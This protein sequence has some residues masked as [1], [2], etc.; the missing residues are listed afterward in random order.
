MPVDVTLAQVLVSPC[1]GQTNMP[2]AAASGQDIRR[3]CESTSHTTGLALVC[4]QVP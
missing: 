1:H 4:G 2:M 3:R